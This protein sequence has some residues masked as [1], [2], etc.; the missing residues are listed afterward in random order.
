[1][2][3]I[4]FSFA[5]KH[6]IQN[7]INFSNPLGIDYPARLIHLWPLSLGSKSNSWRNNFINNGFAILDKY[8]YGFP[9]I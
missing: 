8:L 6:P 9:N 5:H 4:P 7:K 3:K 1:M 2:G